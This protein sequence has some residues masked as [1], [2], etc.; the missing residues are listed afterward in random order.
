MGMKENECPENDLQTR[1][2]DFRAGVMP[3]NADKVS[4]SAET[5]FQGKILCVTNRKLCREDFLERIEM[6]ARSL[7]GRVSGI[8][9]REKDLP[10]EEYRE[11]ARKIME[12]CRKYKVCCI[13][14]NFADTAAE[15]GAQAVHLPLPVLRRLHGSASAEN[16]ERSVPAGNAVTAASAESREKSVQQ[17]S[18]ADNVADSL[19][20]LSQF[21][22][23]GAS[24]HS[25]GDALEAQALGCTYITAGHIFATD[26][27]KGVPPR[28]LAFLREVCDSVSIPV[29]AIGGINGEN[30][31]QVLQAGAAGA[32][33]MSGLMCCENTEEYVSRFADS[34][35]NGD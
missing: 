5:V 32:C 3:H 22:I 9:L 26:C 14:H 8:I 27:K 35:E 20:V 12:I 10:E 33:I 6:V 31:P 34:C 25:V 23:I 7:H 30:Y 1:E 18:L 15:L 17:F 21:R 29:Y 19:H 28:G 2:T 13:L 4:G 16:R 24:C 11:L